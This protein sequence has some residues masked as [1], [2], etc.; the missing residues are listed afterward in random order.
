MIDIH[1]NE[2][3][4]ELGSIE[5]MDLLYRQ[6]VPHLTTTG[7]L[8]FLYSSSIGLCQRQDTI[9][10]IKYCNFYVPNDFPI[11][12]FKSHLIELL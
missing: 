5:N 1:S 11:N 6:F 12:G 7:Y 2:R 10:L 3:H 8:T 9:H 4:R